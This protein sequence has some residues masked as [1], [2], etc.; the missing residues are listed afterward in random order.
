MSNKF[1]SPKIFDD[2]KSMIIIQMKNWQ[3]NLLADRVKAF[4][5]A[6]DPSVT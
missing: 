2:V 6:A 4:Y 3:S 5:C 1:V